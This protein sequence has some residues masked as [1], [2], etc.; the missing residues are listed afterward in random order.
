MKFHYKMNKKKIIQNQSF[1]L[2]LLMNFNEFTKL[3]KTV[4]NK[5]KI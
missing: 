5:L 1:Q 4:D 3:K 2:K